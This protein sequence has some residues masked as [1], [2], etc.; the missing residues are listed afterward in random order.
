MKIISWNVNSVRARLP[1]IVAL[2]ARHQPDLVCLQEIKTSTQ[3][4]PGDDLAAAGYQAA[5]HGQAGRNGVAVLA[6][7]ALAEVSCGFPGEPGAR[8]GPGAV[9]HRLRPGSGQRA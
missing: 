3:T 2:L 9:G 1:R 5:V 4:F 8:A 7:T 6:R